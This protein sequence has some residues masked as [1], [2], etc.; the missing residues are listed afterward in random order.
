VTMYRYEFHSIPL[1]QSKVALAVTALC[2]SC[3]AQSA[4]DQN[5]HAFN[6]SLITQIL[7]NCYSKFCFLFKISM[8]KYG[9]K[10]RS[11]QGFGG[12]T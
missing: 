11:I 3:G 10:E 5:P 8:G 12:D 1:P 4:S 2:K 7:F 9:G 6:F